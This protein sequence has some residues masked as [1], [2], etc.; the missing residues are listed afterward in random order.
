MY[1]A[2]RPNYQRTSK[3][4][5]GLEVQI[6]SQLEKA[7][8]QFGYETI[9]LKYQRIC[10]YIPDFILPNG[11][12]IEGKGWFT[13]Q[14]RS[15]LLLLKKQDP[16]LDIRLVFSKST[17]RLNKKSR[18]TYAEWSTTNGFLWS[19]KVIPQEWLTL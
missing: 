6:A 19:E 10:Y 18:T 1:R 7:G 11:V 17:A 5:S 16:S 2:K 3:Y 14:D 8:V 13:P 12:L 15:K 4:R 9:R